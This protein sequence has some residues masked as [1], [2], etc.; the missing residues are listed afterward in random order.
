M[1]NIGQ[2]IYNRSQGI[3]IVR[4]KNLIRYVSAVSRPQV[5]YL[6]VHFFSYTNYSIEA[7]KIQSIYDNNISQYYSI[8]Q[9]EGTEELVY[10]RKNHN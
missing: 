3:M 2:D 6:V 5:A 4:K 10:L 1:A 8:I 9:P 7:I